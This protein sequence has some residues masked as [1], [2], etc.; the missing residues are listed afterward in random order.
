MFHIIRQDSICQAAEQHNH[1]SATSPEL[2][3]KVDK[4]ILS[5]IA[6]DYYE[7]VVNKLIYPKSHSDKIRLIHDGSLPLGRSMN[8]YAEKFNFH[9]QSLDDAV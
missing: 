1:T 2:K 7:T 4:Q 3:D 9:Y 5:E 6:E 8:S